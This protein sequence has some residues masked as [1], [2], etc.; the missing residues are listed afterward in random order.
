MRH[1]KKPIKRLKRSK[2]QRKKYCS[3]PKYF[4]SSNFNK[5]VNAR[6]GRA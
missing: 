3:T 5:S 6:T 2:S 4:Q 1:L